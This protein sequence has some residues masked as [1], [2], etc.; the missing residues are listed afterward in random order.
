MCAA[1]GGHT[2]VVQVL[3]SQQ[4]VDINMRDKVCPSQWKWTLTITHVTAYSCSSG[5]VRDVGIARKR[6]VVHL[7]IEMPS[8]AALSLT[9]YILYCTF[10]YII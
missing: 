1:G 8:L 3:L 6:G 10:V 7:V 5:Y 2:D 9:A 4:D